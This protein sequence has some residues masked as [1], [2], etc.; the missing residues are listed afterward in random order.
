[1]YETATV[2]PARASLTESDLDRARFAEQF[3]V[4]VSHGWEDVIRLLHS[5]ET[6]PQVREELEELLAA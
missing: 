5:R 1:M 3:L 4:A 2:E 6:D